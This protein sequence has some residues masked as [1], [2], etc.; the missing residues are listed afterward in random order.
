MIHRNAHIQR[1]WHPCTFMFTPMTDFVPSGVAQSRS[2]EAQPY[3]PHVTCRVPR[4][5]Y[6]KFHVDWT[7]TVG[8]RGIHT[9]KR[10]NRQTEISNYIDMENIKLLHNNEEFLPSQHSLWM[11]FEQISIY[12]EASLVHH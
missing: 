9:N 2:G 10:T 12:K 7:K 1:V 5:V 3:L 11:S 8:A 4:S 6:A